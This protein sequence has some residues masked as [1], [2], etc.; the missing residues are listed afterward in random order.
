MRGFVFALMRKNIKKQI[1]QICYE[2]NTKLFY[3]CATGTE[4]Q[5]LLW[6]YFTENL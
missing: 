5:V 6:Y 4:P 3:L 2:G 1:T